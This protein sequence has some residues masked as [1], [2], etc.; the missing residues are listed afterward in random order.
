MKNI[1]IEE[2]AKNTGNTDHRAPAI[3]HQPRSKRY[4]IDVGIGSVCL[5]WPR[6]RLFD[7]G[8]G[9]RYRRRDRAGDYLG[10]RRTASSAISS[11]VVAASTT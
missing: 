5:T 8:L 10:A 7:H 11:S 3:K 6:T 2:Q 4:C 9:I 1:A